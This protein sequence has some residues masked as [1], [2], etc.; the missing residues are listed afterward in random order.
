MTV[1]KVA[2]VPLSIALIGPM[3]VGKSTVGRLLANELGLPFADSDARIEAVHGPIS[4]LFA[5]H[6]E[7]WFRRAEAGIVAQTLAQA[8]LVLSLGGGAVVDPGTAGLIG[9]LRGQG[10]LV[11]VYLQATAEQL[12]GRIL[13]ATNRPLL[14]SGNDKGGTADPVRRWAQIAE[15]RDPRYRQLADVVIAAGKQKPQQIAQEIVRELAE[16]RWA[17]A[18]VGAE[19]S[20]FP[21]GKVRGK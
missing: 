15:Q 21:G 5:R 17:Q 3:L 14:R 2:T 18:E 10:R 12:N 7:P 8:P 1:L 4:E 16:Q 9:Q 11:V 19:V 6:G 13:V 20:E